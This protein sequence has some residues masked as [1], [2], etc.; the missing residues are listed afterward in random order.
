MYEQWGGEW[1]GGEGAK[2]LSPDRGEANRGVDRLNDSD[3]GETGGGRTMEAR[4]W[5]NGDVNEGE[6][7]IFFFPLLQERIVREFDS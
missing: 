7:K 2:T 5:D 3:N 6:L 4:P 1:R